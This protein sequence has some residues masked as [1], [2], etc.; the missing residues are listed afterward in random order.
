V[1][2]R[3]GG[4][5]ENLVDL[6]ALDLGTVL[7]VELAFEQLHFLHKRVVVDLESADDCA[8]LKHGAVP[9]LVVENAADA[10]SQFHEHFHYL[11]LSEDVA[12]LDMGAVLDD[13]LHKLAS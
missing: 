13:V 10:G 2:E 7:L 5:L 12:C 11:D 9:L 1:T 4:M 3:L 8:E 6:A